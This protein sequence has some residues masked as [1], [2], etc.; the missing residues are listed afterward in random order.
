[1]T[2]PQEQLDTNRVARIKNMK[3]L[4]VS[5]SWFPMVPVILG[6]VMGL[7]VL[8]SA[9]DAK[10]HKHRR[11]IVKDWSTH[12]LVF[13]NAGTRDE[14][15]AR[16][17]YDRW[18]KIVND[19]RYIMQQEE[20][21]SAP[22][23]ARTIPATHADDNPIIGPGERPETQ[24][25]HDPDVGLALATD[26]D[27]AQFPGGVLPR[28]LVTAL[29]P[30]SAQPIAGQSDL[31]SDS[32]DAT[33]SK[34]RRNRVKKDW[35]ETVGSGGTTGMGQ[36]PATYSSGG[37]GCSDFA[38]YNT[39][40]A[41]TSSQANVIAYENL[42]SSC[43]GGTPTTYWAYNTSTGNTDVGGS[44]APTSIALSLD[45]TQ[46]ALVE[47]VPYPVAATGTL[48]A[49]P[50]DAYP[51]E[52][53]YD[54]TVG[55][56]TYTWS[57]TADITTPGYMSTS[58]LKYQFQVAQTVYA[59]LTGNRNNCPTSN[60]TC[61]ASNQPANTSVT[62]SLGF[63]PVFGYGVV[64]VTANTPG[65]SGNSI[66]FGAT[67][68]AGLDSSPMNGTLGGGAG[69][70]GVGGATVV[71]IRMGAGGS[72]TS[73]TTPT[74]VSPSSY[75]MCSAPC[76][77]SIQL[78]G[79]PTDTYSS[80]F[81]DYTQNTLYV[82][83]DSGVLH[84]ITRVFTNGAEPATPLEKTSSGWP[85]AVN[86][87]AALGGPVFDS[88]SRNLFVGDY[89]LSGS[90]LGE[91]SCIGT[92]S[93]CGYLHSINTSS[94][95]E[96][97][98]AQLDYNFGIADAPL[99]DSTAGEVYA[100]VGADNTSSC[101]SGSC[102]AVYQFPVD[103]GAGASG[104]EAQV[105]PGYEFLLSGAF[106]N[107]YFT[108]GTGNL[109]VVGNTGPADNTLYQIPITS[110][111]MGATSNV[112]PAVATNYTNGYY[113]AGQQV[114]EFYNTSD[115]NHDY[116]FLSVLSFGAPTSF[117][118]TAS[119]SMGCVEGF[120]VTSGTISSSTTPTGAIAEAGG[121]SGTVVDNG[122][123]GA[124]NIYFSTLLNQSCTTS[125]VTGGCATQTS[126]SAP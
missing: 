46:L 7:S 24:D 123:S 34:K 120:D 36:F 69:T 80:P 32:L 73:P 33:K 122:A 20:H 72:L 81:Y 71:L 35:S 22:Q 86:T 82:G 113:A 40:L 70:V 49:A 53:Y 19:P 95:V 68:V 11:H 61:I 108:T 89:S 92:N 109:Y 83:D 93:P 31:T 60:S 112:G 85:V 39:G 3:H 43:N 28:G 125:G 66:A 67:Q 87:N 63:V 119:L 50:D 17:T 38:I 62:A 76:M 51:P 103:F 106:D 4:R 26:G 16:G 5:F 29:I 91:P 117:C 2:K 96:T 97:T 111:V 116:I 65:T 114:T 15:I 9:H 110:Y 78:S 10:K 57:P 126:Q 12:H 6:L 75:S 1:M 13:S 25:D 102:A 118:G 30:P 48:T 44:V 107:A 101:S 121:A 27:A 8:M 55:S 64:T 79:S 23:A 77:T 41:G 90:S 58:G 98:S 99:L 54:V 18:L 21:A 115:G 47:N 124:S 59:A 45:G 56:S 52:D 37:T 105:G 42:Y 100:F 74:A 84:Q 14:A 88:V 104:T 94:N